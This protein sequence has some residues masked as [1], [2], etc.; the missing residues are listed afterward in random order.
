[1]SS[2]PKQ[3]ALVVAVAASLLIHALLV[4][5]LHHLDHA[6]ASHEDDVLLLTDIDVPPEAPEA[7][8]PS[9]EERA[10]AELEE[11]AA[12][13]EAEEPEPSAT[14]EPIDEAIVEV[15]PDAGVADATAVAEIDIDAGV[16]D[17]TAVAVSEDAATDASM[18]ALGGDGGT[19]DAAYLAATGDGGVDDPSVV[20]ELSGDGGPGEGAVVAVIAD[21][22]VGDGVM[23]ATGSGDGGVGLGDG[24]AVAAAAGGDGGVVASGQGD[25]GRGGTGT[26]GAAGMVDG[27]SGTG[28][29]PPPGADAD[30]L[31]YFPAGEVITVLIRL[32]RIRPTQ[33]APT[34]QAIIAP[35]PD[36]QSLVGSRKIAMADLFDTLVI[37][38]SR[39]QDVV[40]TTLVARYR[41]SPAGLRRFLDRSD[42]PVRWSAARGGALGRRQSSKS[43]IRHDRRVFLMPYPGTVLLVQPR[44]IANLMAKRK[45]TVSRAR[46]RAADSPEW[47]KRIRDIEL[48]SGIDAGPALLL[49]TTGFPR[50]LEV[51]LVG[52]FP[53]PER[54]TLAF[55]ITKGGFVVRGNLLFDSDKRAAEFAR[56]VSARK[57]S[58]LSGYKGRLMLAPFS[59]VNA[60]EGLSLKHKGK[61]VAYATSISVADGQAMLDFA[62][63]WSEAYFQQVAPP[64]PPGRP[65]PGPRK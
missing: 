60:V 2:I 13:E 48:E 45:S 62:G 29:P 52:V 40:A 38:S 63:K 46:L 51:P 58:L 65:N 57:K 39:P 28:T 35:M 50:R 9:E 7:H 26:G 27:T 10:A 19:H 1:M 32:D 15:T 11:A 47:L 22:G 49:T 53:G 4:T 30:L 14:I 33:W 23:V 6:D 61:K 43:V 34:L 59:A 16:V 17:A 12:E 54:A 41:Q 56:L 55:E 44:Y 8:D 37:S 64:P 42:A 21:G 31:S 3:R 20:A 24:G 25:P 18:L 36:F 5:G